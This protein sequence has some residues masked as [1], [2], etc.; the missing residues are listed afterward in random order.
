MDLLE[1]RGPHN[2]NGWKVT[3]IVEWEGEAMPHAVLFPGIPAAEIRKASPGGAHS[4]LTE[5]GMIVTSTQLFVLQGEGRAI[6]FEAGSGNGKT[7]PSEPYW[8]HQ[9]LPYRETLASLGIQPEDIEYVFLS[10]LHQDHVGLATTWADGRWAP[11]FPRAKYVF[12]PREWVYWNSLSSSDPKRHPCID[13]SVLPLLEAGCVQFARAG[14][15][16]GGIRIHE[17]PGHTPG[18]LLFEVDGAGLWFLGDLLHH[19]AQATHPEWAA[20]SFDVDPDL[21]RMQR[22]T[23]FKRFADFDLSLL[24]AHMGGPFRIEETGP[25]GYFVRYGKPQT[26]E[27]CPQGAISVPC[28]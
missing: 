9:N 11:T 15:R 22:L 26:A 28:G 20:A 8:D 12:H 3:R 19:P 2:F 25:G 17:A 10:H 27:K 14:D 18:N 4:R 5:K 13:D 6:L 16:L 24:A 21:G 1:T 7:R 23:Y